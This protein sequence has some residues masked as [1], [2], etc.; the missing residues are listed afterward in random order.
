M[1]LSANE[2]ALPLAQFREAHSMDVTICL[3]GTSASTNAKGKLQKGPLHSILAFS[4][5]LTP[6]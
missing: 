5:W 4:L 3:C 1:G 2:K 6:H